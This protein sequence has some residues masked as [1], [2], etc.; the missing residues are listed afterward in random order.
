MTTEGLA[1]LCYALKRAEEAEKQSLRTRER[2][3]DRVPPPPCLIRSIKLE[4]AD[5]PI[6]KK[7]VQTELNLNIDQL[8]LFKGIG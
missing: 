1:S 2:L 5:F 3:H 7:S 6:E 8:E 4:L